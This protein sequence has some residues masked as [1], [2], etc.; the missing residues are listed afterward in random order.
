M[1]GAWGGVRELNAYHEVL[2]MW[3]FM[4]T[5]PEQIKIL[6]GTHELYREE[7]KKLWQ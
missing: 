7:E 1:Y 3:G 2:E 6:D 4:I 5:D